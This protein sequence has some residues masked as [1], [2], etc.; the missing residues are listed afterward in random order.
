MQ[1]AF[2]DADV[3]VYPGVEATISEKSLSY[4]HLVVENILFA[5]FEILLL[6]NAFPFIVATNHPTAHGVH[7]GQVP[8]ESLLFDV[9]LSR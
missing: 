5:K 4:K 2:V 1:A 9:D 3:V 6:S 7:F 8:L